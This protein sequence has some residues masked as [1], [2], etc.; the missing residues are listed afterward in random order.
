MKTAIV[1]GASSGLG[2]EIAHVLRG[3][4]FNV[5]NW[6]VHTGVDVTNE[7][8]IASELTLTIATNN[9]IDVVVNCAGVNHIEYIPKTNVEDWDRVMA[10]N[11]RGIFLMAKHCAPQMRGGTIC[12]IISNASHVPMTASIAYNASKA[13]AAI[14]TR[15]MARELWATH[16]ITVFGVSPN[17]LR[18]TEMSRATAKRVPA[19]RGWT[20]KQAQQRQ[21]DA[22]LISEET[23]PVAVAGFV[24]YLLKEKFN[25]KYLAGC[26][27]EYGL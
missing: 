12:N 27:M 2:F 25:H 6:D 14:M 13:A 8:S 3:H 5:F 26:I 7:N 22:L 24:G 21:L 10:V 9:K 1:T 17:K 16:K 11:A 15:Q 18:G 19:V 20:A 4:N 23:D